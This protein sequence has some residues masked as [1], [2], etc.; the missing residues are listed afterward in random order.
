M[1]VAAHLEGV[2]AHAGRF[3]VADPRLGAVLERQ[4]KEEMVGNYPIHLPQHLFVQ[5]P[6]GEFDLEDFDLRDGRA[7]REVQRRRRELVSP[8]DGRDLVHKRPLQRGRDGAVPVELLLR[9]AAVERR[10]F[11]Q[12]EIQIFNPPLTVFPSFTTIP[13]R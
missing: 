6:V 9:H 1:V 10:G 5:M 3:L 8:P 4:D 13:S 7:F 11:W 12:V 2:R